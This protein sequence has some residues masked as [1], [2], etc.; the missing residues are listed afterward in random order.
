MTLSL[1]DILPLAAGSQSSDVLRN[2]GAAFLPHSF[3]RD[4]CP[5]LT[6]SEPLPRCHSIGKPGRFA[7]D[8]P[9]RSREMCLRFLLLGELQVT[10]YPPPYPDIFCCSDW[11]SCLAPGPSFVFFRVTSPTSAQDLHLTRARR[12][13]AADGEQAKLLLCSCSELGRCV[14]CLGAGPPTPEACRKPHCSRLKCLESKVGQLFQANA[15]S[16]QT[17]IVLVPSPRRTLE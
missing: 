6:R 3:Q 5:A 17:R 2:S 7:D 15:R 14:S 9:F 8:A 16:S 4:I 11:Q 1:R 12:L 13:L 10:H